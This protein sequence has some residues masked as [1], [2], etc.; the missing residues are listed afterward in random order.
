MA[1]YSRIVDFLP[2][3]TQLLVHIKPSGTF[4]KKLKQYFKHNINN[5]KNVN[6]N[7][8]KNNYVYIPLEINEPLML[9]FSIS[10]KGNIQKQCKD[11]KCK[12]DVLDGEILESLNH[13]YKQISAKIEKARRSEGGNIYH[14]IFFQ[15]KD[16]TW[17]RLED[18]RN[19]LYKPY[20]EYFETYKRIIIQGRKNPI[21]PLDN[22][23]EEINNQPQIL[24][25]MIKI[26]ELQ[27][28]D[29]RIENI[30]LQE[31][32][33]QL[34]TLLEKS[35]LTSY[36]KKIKEFKQRLQEDYAEDN[37]KNSW[38]KWIYENN[39]IFGI[40][41]GTPI[42]HPRVGSE[43]ILDYLF[44][45]PDGFID[46][47][48]IKKP[49]HEVIKEDKSHPGAFKW[50]KEVNEAIGQVI[51]YLSEIELHQLII[52]K[53]LQ[54]ELSLD[55]STI[56]PRAFILIGNSKDWSDKKK[57]AFRRLNHSLHGIS[58]LTYTDLLRRGENLIKVYGD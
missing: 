32:I 31:K 11:C 30:D 1:V 2:E 16:G 38:Q 47:L 34:N 22:I 8:I 36:K 56:K 20:E 49:S 57:E 6:N 27:K 23:N 10:E 28:E 21:K 5:S 14:N 51:K 24:D 40:Q 52:A 7:K 4:D 37:G 26:L 33:E 58:V 41:Y 42:G 3:R 19:E 53:K 15:D 46:I 9:E 13:A 54:Q 25:E 17:K 55:L 45:T 39:W 44:P 43:S 35:K 12:T 29:L 48:E 18:K 50:S